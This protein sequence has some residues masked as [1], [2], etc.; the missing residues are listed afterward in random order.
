MLC[1]YHVSEV[2][3]RGVVA[4]V[5]RL[6]KS[7]RIHRFLDGTL[8]AAP[9]SGNL[10]HSPRS[11][12]RP[13]E[14][15]N[16]SCALRCPVHLIRAETFVCTRHRITARHASGNPTCPATLCVRHHMTASP[17]LGNVIC[18]QPFPAAVARAPAVSAAASRHK[19]TERAWHLVMRLFSLLLPPPRR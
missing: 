1:K 11:T 3:V 8:R 18:S 6:L 10:T 15:G 16:M 2:D 14:F 5:G 19:V 9:A 12:R 17:A 13:P 7:C 4:C